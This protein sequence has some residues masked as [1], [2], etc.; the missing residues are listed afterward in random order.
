MNSMHNFWTVV[1][2]EVVRLLIKP[3]FWI[4]ALGFPVLLAGIF[5]IAYMSSRATSDAVDKLKDQQFSIAYTDES[6][7]IQPA[8]AEAIK[9]KPIEDKQIGVEQ[10][11]AGKLDAYFYYPADLAKEKVEVYGKDVGIFNNG[12]YDTAASF[13]LNKSVD[14]G[15]IDPAQKAVLE[16]KVGQQA[17]IYRDGKQYDAMKEMILPGA[18]LVLFYLLIGF[19]GGQMLSSTIEEKENRTI[20]M[21]LTTIEAKA[22]IAGKIVSLVILA[23]LQATV[24]LVPVLVMYFTIGPHVNMPNFDLSGLPLDWGRI[25][26][27]ALIFGL[28]F[29][30][31]TGLLVALGSAMPTAK[32]ASQWFG[33]IIMFIM[34]PLYGVTSFISYPDSPFVIFL[35][36]FPLTS[37]I[38]LMLRNAVGNLPLGEAILGVVILAV[39]AVLAILLAVRVFQL[40]AMQYD[41]KVSLKALRAKRLNTVVK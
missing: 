32:E 29:L 4:M 10:V 34:G 2:F 1:R 26:M 35:T 25:G 22:L 13:L 33:L 20:E 11:Q 16:G 21:L 31:F 14:G 24:I 30:L 19:F 23:M 40:G 12:R 3:T 38:P 41:S 27:G 8:L 28:S 18:F 6:K 37:P 17:T 5:G 7:M 36:L 9:A 39:A 15:N